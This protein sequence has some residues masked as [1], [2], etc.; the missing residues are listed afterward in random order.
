MV[1]LSVHLCYSLEQFCLKDLTLTE[2]A[3]NKMVSLA[4]HR[5]DPESD[6]ITLVG[7]RWVCQITYVLQ[8]SNMG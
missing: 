7:K 8:D 1:E 6:T 3:R 2:R 5:Y 4:D